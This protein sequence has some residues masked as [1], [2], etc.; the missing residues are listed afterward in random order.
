MEIQSEKEEARILHGAR[1]L[2]KDGRMAWAPPRKHVKMARL[3]R[4]E[5]DGRRRVEA[6]ARRGS[7]S[8]RN[9]HR[10]GCAGKHFRGPGWR[11]V[12]S[13]QKQNSPEEREREAPRE[14]SEEIKKS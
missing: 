7:G 6:E 1:K 12:V 4:G 10:V 3:G 2:R 5:K 13:R 11:A 8:A 9:H 14:G